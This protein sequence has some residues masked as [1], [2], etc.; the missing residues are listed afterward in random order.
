[1]FGVVARL[2]YNFKLELCCFVSNRRLGADCFCRFIDIRPYTNCKIK[3]KRC[4]L[5]V[6]GLS[7]KFDR[8]EFLC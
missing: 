3:Q 5:L 2:E 7:I 8:K 4:L 6:V 1:M